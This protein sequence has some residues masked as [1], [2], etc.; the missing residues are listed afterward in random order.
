MNFNKDYNARYAVDKVF[1]AGAIQFLGGTE[2]LDEAKSFI[3]QLELTN[4]IGYKV[5]DRLES[6]NVFQVGYRYEET[7][8]LE[9]FATVEIP[10][11]VLFGIEQL[12]EQLEG[13]SADA[14]VKVEV[15]LPK[16]KS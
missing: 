12:A 11:S 13:V 16:A 8:W 3:L 10:V 15:S 7:Q 5:W 9:P 6:K 14:T 4:D 2:I 1:K